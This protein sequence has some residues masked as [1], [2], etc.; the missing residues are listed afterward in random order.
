MF[1]LL[2]SCGLE[3]QAE[4]QVRSKSVA[5]RKKKKRKLRAWPKPKALVESIEPLLETPETAEWAKQTLTLIDLLIQCDHVGSSENRPIFTQLQKQI[6]RLDEMIVQASTP[7]N[8]SSHPSTGMLAGELRRLRYQMVRRLVI[9]LPLYEMASQPE[10]QVTAKQSLKAELTGAARIRFDGVEPI[11]HNYLLVKETEAA[12]NRLDGDQESRVEA[13]RKILA[14]VFSPSLSKA[15]AE[16]VQQSLNENSIDFFKSY[17]S[18]PID[19]STLLRN[20]ERHE[21]YESGVSQKYLNDSYQNLLWSSEPAQRRLASVLDTH[22]RNAN[23]RV[24]ISESLINRLIPE[25]PE[26]TEPIAENLL[27]AQVY[28]QTNIRNQLRIRLIPDAERIHLQLESIGSADTSTT[29]LKSG[30]AVQNQGFS[31]FQVFQKLAISRNGIFSDRARAISQSNNRMVG[32]RSNFDQIP[33]V[34]NLARRVA[35]KQVQAQK[36]TADNLTKQKFEQGVEK[37]MQEEVEK[38]IRNMRNVVSTNLIQPLVALELEPEPVQ[39]TTTKEK[40]VVRYRLAG[41][42]QMAA[43]TTRPKAWPGSQLSLQV[44]HSAINNFLDRIG[45]AGNEF[46]TD[47]L[48]THLRDAMGLPHKPVDSDKKAKLLFSKTQPIRVSFVDGKFQIELNIDSF[49]PLETK[50]PKTWRNLKIRCSYAPSVSGSQVLLTREGSISLPGLRKAIT[51][52]LI[53]RAIFDK[54]FEDQYHFD[55]LPDSLAKPM[56]SPDLT[57]AHLIIDNGWL[58]VSL[59]DAPRIA[60]PRTPPIVTPKR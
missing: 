7:A 37:F 24:T 13:S 26:M 15:Q 4:A 49:Q 2:F 43:N 34:G 17:A 5:S 14:R 30:F 41:R 44:H 59:I 12:F 25:M 31:R 6:L 39:M 19:L 36:Q 53:I 9:W 18:S 47:S 48:T 10:E 1:S 57:I 23:F 29:A 33:V 27:G 58:G 3:S 38:Q 51:D 32:I 52:D 16:F 42:D 20:L 60:R 56:N 40:L 21:A 11:W 35:K 45:L 28:G 54:V 55:P 50:R 46:T 8:P 22:Y